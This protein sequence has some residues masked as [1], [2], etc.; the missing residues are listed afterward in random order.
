MLNFDYL[1]KIRQLIE[2]DATSGLG[3]FL[4]RRT[5]DGGDE[6]HVWGQREG[7]NNARGAFFW[8][9]VVK[10]RFNTFP[11]RHCPICLDLPVSV[12]L[13]F[14]SCFSL[15]LSLRRSTCMSGSGADQRRTESDFGGRAKPQP[16]DLPE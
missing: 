12:F 3:Y 8:S 15:A 7:Q 13:S 9:M 6:L 1:L 5:P 10:S 14:P 2:L 16:Q 4:R 11:F